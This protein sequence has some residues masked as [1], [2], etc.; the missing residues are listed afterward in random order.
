MADLPDWVT[1]DHLGFYSSK[2]EK[3]KVFLQVDAIAKMVPKIEA[4]MTEAEARRLAKLAE[5]TGVTRYI[6]DA[7]KDGLKLICTV[8]P[9]AE[10]LPDNERIAFVKLAGKIV[11][12]V[13]NIL[14]PS[15]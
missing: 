11:Q 1:S 10:H 7:F 2:E 9:Y 14:V 12:G 15:E 6:P 5:M 8:A 4:A 13:C 3:L